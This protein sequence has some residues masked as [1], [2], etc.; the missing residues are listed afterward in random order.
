MNA[1]GRSYGEMQEEWCSHQ[2]WHNRNRSKK[3][4]SRRPQCRCHFLAVEAESE[5]LPLYQCDDE[6]GTRGREILYVHKSMS[7]EADDSKDTA[8]REECCCL[9]NTAFPEQDEMQE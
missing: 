5:E 4:E 6:V 8:G 7:T 1:R 3:D 9:S 2:V